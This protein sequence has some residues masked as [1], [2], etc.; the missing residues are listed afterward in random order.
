MGI[1]DDIL[2]FYNNMHISAIV[3]IGFIILIFLITFVFIIMLRIRYG[4]LIRDFR[5]QTAKSRGAPAAADGEPSGAPVFDRFSA[6]RFRSRLL[7]DVVSG[8]ESAWRLYKGAEVNTQAL[9]EDQFNQKMKAGLL[10]ENCAR[11][12]VSVMIVLGLLGTFIGLTISVQSLVLLFKGYDVTELLSSVESGLLS[13][14][15]GMSTAFTTSLFG[16]GCSVIITVMNV[17]INPARYR[18][19]L[20]TGIEEYLDNTVAARLGAAAG[21]GYGQMENALRGTF[22][23]FGERIAERYDRSLTALHDDIRGIED[24]NNNLRN[25]IAQMDVCFVRIADALKSSTRHVEENYSALASLSS[26]FDEISAGFDLVRK[27]NAG[28]S[29]KLVKSVTDAANAI[30]ALTDDLRGEAQRRLDNFNTYNGAID[31]M[32]RSA[33]MIRDAVAAIPDQM[34]AYSEASKLGGLSGSGGFGGRAAAGDQPPK[35]AEP[36]PEAEGGWTIT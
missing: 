29:E 22:I 31:Q 24:A 25:T 2:A 11:H 17:F 3:I 1:L 19:D 26:R 14:L 33:E 34:Y 15:A 10:Q 21:D 9:I 13:A 12:S 5:R 8:Y 20:M 18:E 28:H 30:G 6:P 36:A 23:E 7:R 27:E 16:I 35:Y 32:A 4:G